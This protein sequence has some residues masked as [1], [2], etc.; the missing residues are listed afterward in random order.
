MDLNDVCSLELARDLV[1]DKDILLEDIKGSLPRGWQCCRNDEGRLIYNYLST[2]DN[3]TEVLKTTVHPA[4]FSAASKKSMGNSAGRLPP[5]WD[6]RLD[7]WGNVFYVDH[8]TATAQRVHPQADPNVNYISGLPHGWTETRDHNGAKYFF[9][10]TTLKATYQGSLMKS[11]TS[12]EKFTLDSVP[13]SGNIPPIKSGELSPRRGLQRDEVEGI[14]LL[15][16]EPPV[17]SIRPLDQP[18]TVGG[19]VVQNGTSGIRGRRGS[20]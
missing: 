5:G 8:N 13:I 12:A 7:T 19:M 6:C 1:V 2:R 14:H 3:I 15:L 17:A 16:N 10:T 9:E 18:I 11:D 20:I 4:F